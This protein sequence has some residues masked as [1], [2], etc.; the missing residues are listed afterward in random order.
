LKEKTDNR[1]KQA[2]ILNT[3]KNVNP[4]LDPVDL[5]LRKIYEPSS[6]AVQSKQ[7]SAFDQYSDQLYTLFH[8]V[9]TFF[10]P[11][12]PELNERKHSL[13]KDHIN[14]S[15]FPQSVMKQ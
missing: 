15:L 5:Y 3:L 7:Y 8:D 13:L 9:Y 14:H 2:E 11:E 10:I 12:I 6:D 1:K 4:G